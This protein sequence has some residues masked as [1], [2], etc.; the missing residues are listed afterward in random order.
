MQNLEFG[1]K[2]RELRKARHYSQFQLSSLLGLTYQAVSKWETQ[3]VVPDRTVCDKLSGLLGF[4]FTPILEDNLTPDE[5]GEIV[6]RQKAALWKK[7]RERLTELYGEDPPLAVRNRFLVEENM[8]RGGKGIILFD[9][10]AKVR[11]DAKKKGARFAAPGSECFVSWLLGATDVNPME[12]HL[13]CPKCKK[14]V[15]HPEVQSGWDLKD[16]FCECG[17]RMEPDGQNIPV[18]TCVISAEHLYEFFRCPVDTDYIDEASRIIL[19]CGE[20]YFAME[21]FREEER[22]EYETD[23]ETGGF[24]I[25]PETGKKILNHYMPMSALI[26]KPKKKQKNRKPERIPGPAELVDWGYKPGQPSIVLMGGFIDPPYLQKP[27]PFRSSP[28]ELVRQEIMERALKDYWAYHSAEMEERTGLK[29]PDLERYKGKLTFGK[30]IT[31]ICSVNTLYM[32]SGP[33]ELAEITGKAD[34]T[35]LPLSIEDIWTLISRSTAYPGYMSGA[36]TEIMLKTAHGNYLAGDYLPGIQERD[37]K[38]F[39]E[40]GL[41]D[42]YETYA[43]NVFAVCW[44]TPYIDLGI[45]MLEDARQKI[46]EGK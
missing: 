17:G 23:P 24:V 5:A 3:G 14:V 41:P 25:D 9:I 2:V 29:F 10:L 43:G 35:E 4:D 15:F 42:W 13:R 46:R 33:E 40:M 12:P 34:L 7:A 21:Q 38:L 36:T 39:R 1:K 32:T 37:R 26:F 31:L 30:Y 19:N 18:E 8:L 28:D 45:R 22:E 44:R 11:E 27:G 20:Q 16:E 6:N